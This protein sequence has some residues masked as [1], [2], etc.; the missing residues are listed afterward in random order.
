M[1]FDQAWKNK[2]HTII[3]GIDTPLGK[4]FDIT[5]IF[6]I[7]ISSVAI[8]LDSVDTLNEAYGGFLYGLQIL[9]LFFFTVEYILRVLVAPQKRNYIF[10]F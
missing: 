2:L 3:H 6:S 5:L 8:I 9:F 7:I 4:A 10:S 1:K